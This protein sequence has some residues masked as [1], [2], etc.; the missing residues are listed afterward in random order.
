MFFKCAQREELI[1]VQLLL[2]FITYKQ[3]MP[4]TKGLYQTGTAVGPI[5]IPRVMH[6]ETVCAFVLS[7]MFIYVAV[8][9]MLKLAIKCFFITLNIKT[10][11]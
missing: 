9:S 5:S 6:G 8:S 2:L 11:S 10:Y 1:Y 4:S 3:H 7:F